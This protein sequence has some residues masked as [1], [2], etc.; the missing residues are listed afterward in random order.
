MRRLLA[1]STLWLALS[2]CQP[3][4]VNL[5]GGEPVALPVPPMAGPAARVV[6]AEVPAPII[7]QS[8]CPAASGL[9]LC[10]DKGNQAKLEAWMRGLYE[11]AKQCR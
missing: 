11:A 1:L 8:A 3:A 5:R 4:L 6:N 9:S 2:G 10:F 7:D